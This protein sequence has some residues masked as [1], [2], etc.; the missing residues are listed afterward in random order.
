MEED[1]AKFTKKFTKDFYTFPSV[2]VLWNALECADIF[3]PSKW[4]LAQFSKACCNCDICCLSRRKK[5]AFRK[6][7]AT[8]Q[9]DWNCYKKMQ[10]ETRQMCRCRGAHDD[11]VNNM[12][13]EPGSNNKNL[14]ACIKEMNCNSSDVAP[15]KKDLE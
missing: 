4:T 3:V 15:L 12:L 5:R 10:K 13:S 1:L 6:A 14:F 7:C 2:N 8:K 11:Y 9:S